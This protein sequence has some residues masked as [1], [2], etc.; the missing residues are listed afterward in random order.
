MYQIFRVEC[1]DEETDPAKH[2]LIGECYL[3]I[4]EISSMQLPA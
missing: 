1:W 3:A 4:Q 2:K